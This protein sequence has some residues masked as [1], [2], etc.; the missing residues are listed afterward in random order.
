MGRTEW[1]DRERTLL[2]DVV[3]SLMH[4]QWG[5]TPPIVFLFLKLKKTNVY[6]D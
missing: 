6:A 2:G 1:P 3:P 4:R 5:R